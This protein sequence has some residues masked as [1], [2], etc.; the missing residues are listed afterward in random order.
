MGRAFERWRAKCIVEGLGRDAFSKTE[1][2]LIEVEKIK[3]RNYKG[4]SMADGLI[5]RRSAFPT[6]SLSA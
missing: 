5:P 6:S 4:I 2:M 1:V 3:K